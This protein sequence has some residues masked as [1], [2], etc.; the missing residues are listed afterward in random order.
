[1]EP[2]DTIAPPVP[3]PGE[4]SPDGGQLVEALEASTATGLVAGAGHESA[5]RRRVLASAGIIATGQLLSSLLGFVRIEM[6]NI[7]F[8]PIASGA[9][10]VALRPVQMLSDL[11]VGQSV[12]GALIPTFVDYGDEPQREELRRIYSTVVN[13]VLLLMCVAAA[14]LFLLAPVFIPFW[15]QRYGPAGQQLAVSLAR[16]SAFALFGLGLYAATSALLYALKRVVYP[17]FAI[18]VQHVGVVL[19][20]TVGLLLAAQHLGLPL[21]S[22]FSRGQTSDLVSQARLLGAGGLAVGIVAGAAGEFLLLLP[23][24]RQARIVW[25]PVL[26]LRH[27]ALRQILRLYLPIVIGLLISLGQQSLDAFLAG[28][29]PGGAEANVTALQSG[30]VLTQFP[31]GLV[32]A[33]L[34]FAVLPPLTAAAS[35]NDTADFKRTLRLG[36]RLGLLLMVPAMVGLIVLREPIMAMLFQHGA[37]DHGCTVRNALA[38]Q[39]YAYQL[40]F[41]AIDQLLIAAF[42]ARKNTITPVVVGVVSIAFY[43]L[44]AVPFGGTIGMPAIAFANAAL[45]S[46]HAIVLFVLLTL[47]IGDLGM[48]DLLGS[49]ARI[50]VAAA[51]MGAICWAGLT[52]LPRISPNI[53]GLTHTGG[54]ALTFLVAGAAGAAVYFALVSLLGIEELRLIGEMVRRRLGR[55]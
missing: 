55:R 29:T 14:G 44:V 16:I 30:T 46:G 25:R 20:G 47:T 6:L 9:F 40:P 2:Q 19:G 39:N 36:F 42:Y 11:L 49:A 50:L 3:M 32:A 51:A 5:G 1:M 24:L 27:P 12:S 33:A 23:G 10:L 18:G 41:I 43:V 35:R 22:A 17:A 4:P 21:G 28:R 48:R 34:S 26:S 54:E 15:T 45:N 37:C 13:I 52:V 53:F 7:L 38:V 8:F 31:V